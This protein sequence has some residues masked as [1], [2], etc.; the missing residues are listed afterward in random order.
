MKDATVHIGVLYLEIFIPLSGSLKSKRSVLK[1][2]KDRV[3]S[4]FNVSVAEVGAHDKWQ[5]SV[6]AFGAVSSDKTH[7]DRA[8]QGV[9]SFVQ[10]NHEVELISHS[11]EIL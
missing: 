8:L 7:L 1:S 10:E 11:L 2:L 9:L 6:L 4:R 5:R 3:R